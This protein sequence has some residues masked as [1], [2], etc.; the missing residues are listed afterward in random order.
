ME[1]F[2]VFATA[3]SETNKQWGIPDMLYVVAHSLKEAEQGIKKQGVEIQRIHREGEC[4]LITDKVKVKVA[5][6][7]KVADVVGPKKRG[8]P[9]GTVAVAKKKVV[10]R[11][12]KRKG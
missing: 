7:A 12:I 1:L 2:K 9:K 8:R 11:K 10:K 4:I 5:K 3:K 6:V